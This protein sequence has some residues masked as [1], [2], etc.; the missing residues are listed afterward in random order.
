MSEPIDRLQ[1]L[2]DKEDIRDVLYRYARGAD[3]L[4]IDMFRSVFWEDGGYEDSI[5]EG[6][7]KD[8]IP[9]LIGDTVRNMFATTQ[10]FMMNVRFEFEST[11]LAFTEC[12]YLAFHLLNPDKAALDSVL[13]P[14]RIQ[15]LGGDY[16]RSYELIVAGRYLDRF[17]RRDSLWRIQKRRFISDW[18]TSGLA[19]G[20]GREGLAKLWRLCGSRNSDDP[21]YI[22]R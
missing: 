22:H 1:R 6:V 15:E 12:Y 10:H 7:A 16:S 9:T 21:S 19:S 20:I 14:R 13:G 5:V 8:F 4:D 18:T 2:I 17:E 3:R 11:S